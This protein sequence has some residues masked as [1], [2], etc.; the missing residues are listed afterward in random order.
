[1]VIAPVA[2][3]LDFVV[4]VTFRALL[5]ALIVTGTWALTLLEVVLN[6]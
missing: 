1:M 2:V 4:M 3:L 6:A 5:G